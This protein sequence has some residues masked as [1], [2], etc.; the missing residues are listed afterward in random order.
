MN[1]VCRILPPGLDLPTDE[2]ERKE[3]IAIKAITTIAMM[4][5]NHS[6]TQDRFADRGAIA[7]I[8]DFCFAKFDE[9]EQ[10]LVNVGIYGLMALIANNPG[11]KSELFRRQFLSYIEPLL[12]QFSNVPKVVQSTLS[13]LFL[14][15]EDD[16]RSRYSVQEARQYCI[17]ANVINT[18]MDLRLKVKDS[19]IH[20][21]I[22]KILNVVSKDLS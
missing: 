21:T 6:Q 3:T 1:L 17:H 20:T 8:I 4:A 2:I 7:W 15:L 18:I 19:E 11:N 5:Y 22:D 12:L 13:L 14:L 16:I 10:T 9:K